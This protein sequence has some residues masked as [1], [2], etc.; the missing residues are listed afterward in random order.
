M[1]KEIGAGGLGG[2]PENADG[3]ESH[4]SL[5][6]GYLLFLLSLKYP[7]RKTGTAEGGTPSFAI[8]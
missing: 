8:T 7:F 4:G 3:E 1:L 5:T 2:R 6:H